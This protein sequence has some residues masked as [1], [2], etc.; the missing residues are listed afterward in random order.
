M[1]ELSVFGN[2]NAMRSSAISLFDSKL[3]HDVPCL[4]LMRSVGRV[5]WRGLWVALYLLLI[6]R[7]Q[8]HRWT[9][10]CECWDDEGGGCGLRPTQD[11]FGI[12]APHSWLLW[13]LAFP[14]RLL[15]CWPFSAVFYMPQC[16]ACYSVTLTLQFQSQR[17]WLCV[18]LGFLKCC[19]YLACAF[20]P[21]FRWQRK[22]LANFSFYKV[23]LQ[24]LYVHFF[25]G[26]ERSPVFLNPQGIFLSPELAL[27]SRGW[28]CLWPVMRWAGCSP[29]LSL[30]RAYI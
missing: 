27:H 20:S 18:D 29:M 22:Q 30:L 3:L 14:W 17:S 2:F 1:Q 12:S 25:T 5:S 16:P 8:H 7:R 10:H 23:L 28:C 21:F 15:K 19:I 26:T 4:F 6:L 9:A 13:C 11:K 24:C